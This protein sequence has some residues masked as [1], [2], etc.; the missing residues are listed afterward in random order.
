MIKEKI[1]FKYVLCSCL[2]GLF[3]LVGCSD[4]L[5]SLEQ[6]PHYDFQKNPDAKI[7]DLFANLSCIQLE[8]TEDCV[9]PSI[10]KVCDVNGTLVVLSGADEIY[11][12][13]KKSGKCLGQ[14]SSKGEGPEEYVEA[15]DI[16][17]D[18]TNN[19]G[20]VDRL[21]GEVKFF[22]LKGKF[23]DCKRVNGEMAWMENAEMANDG[24]LLLSN[25]LT[26]GMPPQKYA[27]TLA[28]FNMNEHPKMFDPFA[29]VRVSNYSVA[30]ASKPMTRIGD[31]IHF[32][33]FLND[34]LF[35]Y[36]DGIVK[37]V[38]KLATPLPLPS[39]ETVAKQ[40]E[41]SAANLV[42]LA[43]NGNFFEGFDSFYETSDLLLFVPT[44]CVISGCYW[45]DK[46]SGKAYI[47]SYTNDTER[48]IRGIAEGK[49]VPAPLGSSEDELICGMEEEIM[50]EL[51]AKAVS[52]GENVVFSNKLKKFVKRIDKEGNPCLFIY[53]HKK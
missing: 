17:V 19:I 31:E 15:T 52:N 20:I 34:T 14:I 42:K 4:K 8:A 45:V 25:Q 49:Y 22:T 44:G 5:T 33:K 32:L 6:V 16:V 27:Y 7:S 11:T 46:R 29:P 43:Y 26:G 12:F 38:C 37:S 41:Y 2:L 10:R 36:K 30:F 39:R 47:S 18:A 24:K 23:V 50:L 3:A 48:L 9:V 35:S 53:S 13:N 1:V 51:F 40:C 21:R 28:G